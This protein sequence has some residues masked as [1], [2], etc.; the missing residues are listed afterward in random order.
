MN[1]LVDIKNYELKVSNKLLL[2]KKLQRQ[3]QL[4]HLLHYQLNGNSNFSKQTLSND[5]EMELNDPDMDMRNVEKATAILS[6]ENEKKTYNFHTTLKNT[7]GYCTE[8]YRN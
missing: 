6:L 5:L 7:N 3:L 8:T 4:H 2:L 1:I